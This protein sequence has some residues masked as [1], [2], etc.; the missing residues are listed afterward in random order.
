MIRLNV[1]TK[2]FS[3]TREEAAFFAASPTAVV[4]GKPAP[5]PTVTSELHSHI[6]VLSEKAKPARHRAK[7][8]NGEFRSNP[9]QSDHVLTGC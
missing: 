5:A 2:T 3:L 9:P 1:G 4:C 6:F 7:K 8:E